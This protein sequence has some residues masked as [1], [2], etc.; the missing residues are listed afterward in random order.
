M[1]IIGGNVFSQTTS[2]RLF[3]NEFLA[4]NS[5]TIF[6]PDFQEYSDWIEIYN[7]EDS[8]IYLGDFYLTDDL[9]EPFKWKIPDNTTIRPGWHVLFWADGKN[10]GRHTNFKLSKAGE[11]IGLY[12]ADGTVIDTV[13]YQAQAA[14]I[15]FG[16]Y[17]DG[18][19]N[20]YF[21][22]EPTPGAANSNQIFRGIAP[23]PQFSIDGGFYNG[24]LVLE[25]STPA[26]IIIRYT[27]D[28]SI[29]GTESLIYSSPILIDSTTAIRAQTIKRGYLS[30][31]VI[32]H[33]YFIDENISLPVV[34]VVTDPANLWDDEVGIYVEGTNG[35]PGYCNTTPKNWN[36]D[37]ERPVSLELF[38]QD[39][40]PGFKLDAGMKIGGGCTRKYP[41]KSLAIYVR[42]QYGTSKIHYQ[43]FKDKPIDSFNN[44]MLR[45]AGQD[46]Y[47]TFFRDGMMQVLVKDRM[48]IDWQAFKPAV[49][50]LNG[51]YWGIHNI[52][53]KHNE[54]YLESNYGIDGDN[55]DILSGNASVKQGNATHYKNLLNFIESNNLNSED[56]YDYVKTQMEIDE[57]LNYQISEIYFANI[58]WPG[59]NIKYWRPQTETG[60]W[61]WILFDTDLGF[62]AHTEGQYHSNS[63]ANATATT[64]SYYANPPWST[65]LFRKLLENTGFKNDFIQRFASHLNTTFA[66]ERALVIIDSLKAEIAP[67]IPRHKLKWPH[68]MSFGESWNDLVEI[69]REFAVKRPGHV[70]QHIIDKFNLSGTA[71]LTVNVVEP[72][73]GKI[74]INNVAIPGIS[75][76]GTYFKDIPINCQ[77]IP[78]DGYHFTGWQ[79]ISAQNSDSITIILS[80]DDSLKA[81]FE[82]DATI[83]INDVYINEFLAINNQGI[84]DKY[85]ENDDWIELFNGGDEAVDIGGL[86]ITDD[87]N[88]P[89]AWQIPSKFPD[90]TTIQP[91]GFLLLW[92]DK[93][94]AQGLLH[95]NIKLSGN[96]E[97]IGLA[98]QTE[99][100]F[101]YIDSLNFDTQ[102]A[103]VSYGRYPD[104]DKSK[105]YFTQPTPGSENIVP[106][107]VME[108]HQI[109]I[110]TRLEQNFPNPFNPITTIHFQISTT[111]I[112]TL[113]IYD[114][115]GKEVAALINKKMLGGSYEIEFN[116][117]NLP[118]GV[119]FYKM[120][121]G[122]FVDTKKLLLIK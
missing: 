80:D 88:N 3:I 69:M 21:I 92:A 38:E 97:Q 114:I 33:T 19:S 53:E 37:W 2:V 60:K 57:Y 55:I 120:R 89:A 7:A 14:D 15:S 31:S 41:Q 78:D 117:H 44:I 6:D 119:Y 122:K 108:D 35:I 34:S 16:C 22:D 11:Q 64:A 10:Q 27:L 8:S 49:L 13:F 68:S 51:E 98:Q 95:V 73:M 54:H 100:G 93:D 66:P 48:D 118:G 24:N 103:D 26:T 36:Q 70:F 102:T 9:N 77:A 12:S 1:V 4:S 84:A 17:P 45:N 29:P 67:E 105:S 43:I 50:F 115:L 104:G 71:K 74:L 87:L 76:Q 47:R 116:G 82:H 111:E 85:G 107:S 79:G 62:G 75:F 30:G 72:G 86:Y 109:P 56:N 94:T 113:K 42:N 81:I 121:A 40:S 59:G 63:L 5:T 32:T 46:W 61:R 20:R 91:G 112:V 39:G 18:D 101:V 28:G 52:R 106:I 23:I 110:N 83:L 96:G 25:L 65:F 90:S 99:T 58:D